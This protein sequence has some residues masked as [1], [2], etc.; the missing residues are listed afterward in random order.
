MFHHRQQSFLHGQH[1]VVTLT[2]QKRQ[3]SNMYE[4]I[5]KSICH[6]KS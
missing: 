4:M 2:E 1:A 5:L 3:F 6:E